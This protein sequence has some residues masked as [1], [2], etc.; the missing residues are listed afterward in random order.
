MTKHRISE[1]PDLAVVNPN[2][3]AIDVGP[4][5]HIA[6]ARVGHGQG[7]RVAMLTAS[8]PDTTSSSSRVIVS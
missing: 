1:H 5:M 8:N 6:A 7:V 2:A 3:A 4:T